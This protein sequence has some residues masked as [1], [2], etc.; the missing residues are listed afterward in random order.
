MGFDWV[1]PLRQ[2]TI[3]FF[4]VFADVRLAV[5]IN[6]TGSFCVANLTHALSASPFRVG[7]RVGC[8]LARLNPIFRSDPVVFMCKQHETI[9][10]FHVGCNSKKVLLHFMRALIY[11]NFC[12]I[13]LANYS[14]CPHNSSNKCFCQ[15]EFSHT[16]QVFFRLQVTTLM[17]F[18]ILL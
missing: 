3:G 11:W 17:E 5:Q 7:F 1:G 16:V 18:L 6:R 4:W 10:R 14:F 13:W 12:W 15:R 2:Q 9:R 8:F